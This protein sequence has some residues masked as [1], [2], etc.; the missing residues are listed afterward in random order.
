MIL[1]MMRTIRSGTTT[2]LDP[3]GLAENITYSGNTSFVGFYTL[4][5]VLGTDITQ[6]PVAAS[7][8][9]Y[10]NP[11]NNLITIKSAILAGSDYDVLCVCLLT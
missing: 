3:E 10:P 11:G 1:I 6:I 2:G 9:I 4:P 7:L 8:N 5:A